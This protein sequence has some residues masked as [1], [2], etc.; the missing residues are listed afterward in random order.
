MAIAPRTVA[1][2]PVPERYILGLE[3]YQENCGTCHMAMPPAVMPRETWQQLL[4]LE[5]H[6]GVQ[7]QLPIDP[8][9][10]LIWQYLQ[11]ASRPRSS[12]DETPYRLRNSRYFQAL[13]P[14]VKLTSP[15]TISSCLQ[16]HPGAIKYDFRSLTPE[17]LDSQ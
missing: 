2:D 5:Q 3:L 14:R 4:L 16:C 1:V 17:W 6:Y 11:F 7:V 8:P 13:H 12:E 9:R 15:I 10:L